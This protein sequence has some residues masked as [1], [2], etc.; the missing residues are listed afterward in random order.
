LVVDSWQQQEGGAHGDE[1]II[2]TALLY[3]WCIDQGTAAKRISSDS[4]LFQK[5]D[6]AVYDHSLRSGRLQ[7]L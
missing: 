2:G 5:S 1:H 7:T 6:S 4:G 3:S